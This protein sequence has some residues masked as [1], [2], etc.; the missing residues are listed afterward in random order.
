MRLVGPLHKSFVQL[1][2]SLTAFQ[3][4]LQLVD[5]LV[6]SL[7]LFLLLLQTISK[8]QTLLDPSLRSRWSLCDR[9]NQC[10]A[11]V[12]G[13]IAGNLVILCNMHDGLV[14][15]TLDHLVVPKPLLANSK[16]SLDVGAALPRRAF[17]LVVL[18]AQNI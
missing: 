10:V 13:T 3:F 15:L 8:Q 1:N 6:Q 9:L 17:K 5:L 14:E 2:L 18:T 7:G 11:D 16:L 12:V 4:L